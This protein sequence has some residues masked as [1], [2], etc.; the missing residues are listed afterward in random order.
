MIRGIVACVPKHIVANDD[1]KF[2]AATGVAYRRIA[3]ENTDSMQMG[4]LAAQR[5]LDQ[6]DWDARSLGAIICVT[7]TPRARMPG[8][9]MGI[10][11]LLGATCPAF[12]LN[13]ACSGY[14]YALWVAGGLPANRVLIIAGD[15][16]SRMCDPKDAGTTNL[17]GDAVT[18]TAIDLVFVSHWGMGTDGTGYS[19]LIADPMIHMNGPEVMSFAISKVP[20][21]V[22]VVDGG[23]KKMDWHLFHQANAFILNHIR[24]KCGLPISKVPMNISKYG[25]TSSASIPLLMADSMCTE[26]LRK[27]GGRVAM[28]GFGAGFSYGSCCMEL[29]PVRVL[30]VIEA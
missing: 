13:M 23:T 24:K 2:I 26:S 15:T 30:E 7:Q 14:V 17:F 21:L 10:A 27:H 28:Y 29:D 16:V 12:D 20:E 8:N 22:S 6:L 18:A 11:G 3:D 19:S 9:A 5:L 1:A 4:F 25:N